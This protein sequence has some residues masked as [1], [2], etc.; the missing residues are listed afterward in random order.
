MSEHI[1]V[2][3]KGE[4]MW[5]KK[6]MDLPN[7]NFIGVLDNNPVS[8]LHDYKL[9]DKIECYQKDYGDF[10]SWEPLMKVSLE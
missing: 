5:V 9:S 2:Y 8:D 3:F 10:K 4:S 1:K 6:T 7:G